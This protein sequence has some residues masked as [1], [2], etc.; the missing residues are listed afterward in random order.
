MVI[1][2][3]RHGIAVDREDPDCPPDA[4]RPLT[5]KGAGKARQVL[6]GLRELGA[7]PGAILSSPLLRAWQ[8][9]E[10]AAT[11]FHFP[12]DKIRR[13]EALLPEADPAALLKELSR[14]SVQEVLCAGHAPHLDEFLA[15]ATGHRASFTAL[16]KSGVAWLDCQ[17]LAPGR[18]V[19]AALYPPRA[20]RKLA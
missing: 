1:Y 3:V 17:A 4:E 14:L 6:S 15:L 18:A 8:T 16:K 5:K 19:L 13:T 11:V 9:G 10:I 7:K 12:K 2:L 20:L